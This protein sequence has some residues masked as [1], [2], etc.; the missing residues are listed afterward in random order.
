[1]QKADDLQSFKNI[2]EKVFPVIFRIAYRITGDMDIAE[3]LCQEAFLRY[4]DKATPLASIDEVKYWLIRVVKNLAYNHE[5]RKG[6]E[7]SAYEKLSR[8]PQR[9]PESGENLFIK[10]EIRE[11]VQKAL[12]RLPYKLR[13]TL[14]MRE[15][16]GL[17]YKEIAKILK[18][19]EG[20]VKVRVFRARE[21]LG[22]IMKEG[23]YVP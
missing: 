10:K 15:Y 7:K 23:D 11:N 14:V 3:D 2:Y 21:I 8:L 16:G 19:S 12:N 13:I 20:N 5:K 9:S 18:I 6:R 4:Y 17:S 22:N 1:M